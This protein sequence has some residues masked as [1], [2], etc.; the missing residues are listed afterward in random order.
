MSVLSPFKGLPSLKLT[1]HMKN[2]PS[3]KEISS[4]NH[5]FL[6]AILVSRRVITP[7]FGTMRGPSLTTMQAEI[8]RGDSF[9]WTLRL[10]YRSWAMRAS[11]PRGLIETFIENMLRSCGIIQTLTCLKAPN[12][13]T[14]LK[15]FQVVPQG[16]QRFCHYLCNNHLVMVGWWKGFVVATGIRSLIAEVKKCRMCNF[17]I[18][19]CKNWSNHI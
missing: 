1:W 8:L 6:G 18:E 7:F 19:N 17:W 5:Q 11:N 16:L 15:F 9:P 4:S 2:R 13:N 12:L 14:C 3:Q 10:H